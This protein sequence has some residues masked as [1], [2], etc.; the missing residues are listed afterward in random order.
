MKTNPAPNWIGK[1]PC[2]ATEYLIWATKGAKPTYNLDYAKS[3]NSGKNIK[4]VF[5]TSLTPPSEKK[6][7]KFPCQ[8]RLE[9]LTDHLINL[10]SNEG[11]IILVPFAGSGTECIASQINKR[12]WISF[13][14]NREYMELANMRLDDVAD[15]N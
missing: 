13:E 6:K 5:Q 2:A 9:G 10:H 8:K 14:T 11:D 12:N 1:S 4:N 7:G 3:I 15:F